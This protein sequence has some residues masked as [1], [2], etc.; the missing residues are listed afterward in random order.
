MA[1]LWK[2][3]REKSYRLIFLREKRMR[4]YAAEAGYQSAGS[5]RGEWR[6]V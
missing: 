5:D 1:E 2:G 3:K 4:G 6:Y